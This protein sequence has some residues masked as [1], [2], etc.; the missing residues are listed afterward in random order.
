M[1]T[2]KQIQNPSNGKLLLVFIP[3]III[4]GIRIASGSMGN[5]PMIIGI[6]STVIYLGLL[7]YYCVRQKCYTQLLVNAVVILMAVGF[8]IFQD[9]TST[10]IE[11]KFGNQS[12]SQPNVPSQSKVMK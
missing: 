3:F 1:G 6:I 5:W 2:I 10:L 9:Y 11:S 12:H 4:M 8:F 7:T